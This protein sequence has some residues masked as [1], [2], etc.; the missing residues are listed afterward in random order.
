MLALVKSI[1][2]I[3][4]VKNERENCGMAR[5]QNSDNYIVTGKEGISN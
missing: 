2:S 1:Y 5:N 3:V 4:K